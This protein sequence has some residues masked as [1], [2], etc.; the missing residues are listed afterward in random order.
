MGSLADKPA[1]SDQ[2]N[3]NNQ[4]LTDAFKPALG[5]VTGGGNM[6]GSLLG[7]NGGPAQTGALTNFANS[8]GMQFLRQQGMQGIESSQAAKGLLQSG[9]TLKAMDK[10]NNGLASTYLNQFMSNLKDYAGIGLG[11]GNVLAESGVEKHEKGAKKGILSTLTDAA[12][13]GAEAYASGGAS[14]AAAA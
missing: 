9:S 10:F 7:V 3:V 5:Y 2:V 8:G 12:V 14:A 11:A 6:M 4:M 1:K 13:A